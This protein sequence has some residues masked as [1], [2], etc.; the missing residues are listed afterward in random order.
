MPFFTIYQIEFTELD[1]CG[2][3]TEELNKISRKIIN[4]LFFER[5][6]NWFEAEAE[7]KNFSKN[8]GFLSYDEYLMFRPFEFYVPI[9]F[10]ELEISSIE[11]KIGK[12]IRRPSY[13]QL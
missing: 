10:I 7:I 13:L 6:A 9:K 2:T 1:N 4:N 12:P 5:L 11:A 8:G 3:E